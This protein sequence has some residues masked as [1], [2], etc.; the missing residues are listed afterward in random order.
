MSGYKG[1]KPNGGHVKLKGAYTPTGQDDYISL[2]EQVK[3]DPKL[4]AY[5][6]SAKAENNKPVKVSHRRKERY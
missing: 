4:M 5:L 1:L 3:S 2:S 6:N